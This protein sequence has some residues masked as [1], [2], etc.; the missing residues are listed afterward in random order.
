MNSEALRTFLVVHQTGGFSSAAE[1]L[2]RSQPAISR[3]IALLEDELRVPL[4]ERAAMGVTLTAAGQALFPHA[5]R[6]LAAMGDAASAVAGVRTGIAG[7][8]S[9]AAVGTLAGIG[10][11]PVLRGFA[12]EHP[13]VAL[14]IRTATSAE[15]SDLVRRGEATIGLRYLPD[16]SP[17]VEDQQIGAEVMHV[18]CRPDHPARGRRLSSLADLADE[19]WFAFPNA[20]SFRETFADNLFA[21]FQAC[22]VATV[23]WTPVDSQTAQKRLVEAGF[24]LALLP[25]TAIE[26]ELSAGTMATLDVAGLTATNPIHL[27][28][29]R[30]GYLSPAAQA[31]IARLTAAVEALT[32]STSSTKRSTHSPPRS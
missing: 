12:S 13:G 2:G 24:G 32:T 10:L 26:D 22:G 16:A 14:S 7:P 6:V 27:V 1:A 20:W 4:F 23:R 21:Q 3:R 31:L 5:E 9:L 28:V 25:G 29:R 15:V 11:A 18:A 19:M 17:D 8:V 30:G